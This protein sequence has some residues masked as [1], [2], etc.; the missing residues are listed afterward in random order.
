MPEPLPAELPVSGGE[1]FLEP[2]V[3][4]LSLSLSWR[5]DG[6]PESPPPGGSG[7]RTDVSMGSCAGWAMCGRLCA[8]FA[9]E[10]AEAP[11]ECGAGR[12][13]REDDMG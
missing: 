2:S 13:A 8:L 10:L 1:A 7:P 6:G 9:P 4:L 11:E 12:V 5:A 3:D